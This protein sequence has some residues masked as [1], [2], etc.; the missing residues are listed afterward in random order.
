MINSHAQCPSS[1]IPIY[2]EKRAASCLDADPRSECGR[3]ASFADL[4]SGRTYGEVYMGRRLG[5]LLSAREGKSYG[6]KQMFC[7]KGRH[8]VLRVDLRSGRA[9]GEVYMGRRL[10]ILLSARKGKSYRSRRTSGRD[11][12]T[13]RSTWADGWGFCF[14]AWKGKSCESRRTM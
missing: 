1:R 11:A 6:R 2:I 14:L 13:A 8:S 10:G 3:T 12:P 7:K 9:Y 4:R 5:I